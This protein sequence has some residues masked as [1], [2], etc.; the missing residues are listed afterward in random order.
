MR[1]PLRGG[2]T[3]AELIDIRRGLGDLRMRIEYPEDEHGDVHGNVDTET[4]A[5]VR[6]MEDRTD[7]LLI[8]RA[9]DITPEEFLEADTQVRADQAALEAVGAIP[10]AICQ[11]EPA[12][13]DRDIGGGEVMALGMSCAGALD[14]G[15]AQG[16]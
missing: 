9:F 6:Q 13:R 15:D 10:C 1:T 8:L 16:L 5:Q 2:E 3:T 14:E 11:S 4:L 12:I 7:A